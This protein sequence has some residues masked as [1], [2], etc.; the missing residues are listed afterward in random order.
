MWLREDVSVASLVF[1]PGITQLR[2]KPAYNPYTEPSMEVFSYHQG[3]GGTRYCGREGGLRLPPL[4]P[5]PLLPPKLT[6][7]PDITHMSC[8][9]ILL[10]PQA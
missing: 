7:R 9:I 4:S 8:P 6:A 10:P 1:H 3:Q 5:G 2:F